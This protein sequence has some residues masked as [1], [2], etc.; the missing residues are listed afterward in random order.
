MDNYLIIGIDPGAG[1]GLSFFSKTKTPEAVKMPSSRKEIFEFLSS[2]KQHSERNNEKVLVFIEKVNL[3]RGDD[4]TPG[5]SFGIMKLLGNFETLQTCFEILEMPFVLVPAV[6][7]QTT[8]NLKGRKGESKQ[9]RKKRYSE[10]ARAYFPE[11]KITLQTA[12]AY[13]LLIFGKKKIKLDPDWINSRLNMVEND[14][15]GSV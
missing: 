7:W 3:Y 14:L 5:K 9:E 8:L 4:E 15:F 10:F 1:G 13:C 2:L 12:D 11:N 6:T